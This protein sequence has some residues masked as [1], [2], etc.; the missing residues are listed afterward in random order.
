MI[1]RKRPQEARTIDMIVDE[2][3]RYWKTSIL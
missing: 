3:C 2:K 1:H